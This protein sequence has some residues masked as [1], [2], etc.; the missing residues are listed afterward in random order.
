MPVSTVAFSTVQS[1]TNL[2]SGVATIEIG[3]AHV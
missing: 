1:N 3:R 2:I